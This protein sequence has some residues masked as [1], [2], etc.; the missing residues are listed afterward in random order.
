MK[1]VVGGLDV[2]FDHFVQA[3]YHDGQVLYR[4]DQLMLR[5]TGG[6]GEF[7]LPIE[8][9]LGRRRPM[10]QARGGCLH[11]RYGLIDGNYVLLV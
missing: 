9:R 2:A 7:P 11:L 5:S 8:H 4:T 3:G 6:F 1:D 10:G